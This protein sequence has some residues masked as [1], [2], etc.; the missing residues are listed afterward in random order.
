MSASPRSKFSL[1][2]NSKP[3]LFLILVI[4]IWVTISVVKVSYRKYLLSREA[5]KVKQEVQDLD[6]QNSQLQGYLEYLRSDSFV[7]KEARSKLN[8][9]KEGENVV[10]VPPGG[11][12]KETPASQTAS[13]AGAFGAAE[14]PKKSWWWKWW[15]YFF[16]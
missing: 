9:K 14:Q 3:V 1:I 11:S 8:L 10:V 5:E 13:P 15:E 6:K 7:E 12:F 16:E 2:F 4:L